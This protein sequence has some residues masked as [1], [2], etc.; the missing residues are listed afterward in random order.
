MSL[1]YS[2]CCGRF[3]GNCV[4]LALCGCGLPFT[5]AENAL[6][7]YN[8]PRMSPTN[9]AL[10]PERK[11]LAPQNLILR[12]AVSFIAS[13]SHSHTHTRVAARNYGES[14]NRTFLAA[15]ERTSDGKTVTRR[16]SLRASHAPERARR[17]A[18]QLIQ[19]IKI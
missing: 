16:R 2:R 9:K 11:A 17:R 8:E 3:N 1:F 10:T 7:Y 18:S 13:P 19:S 15:G 12:D 5:A 4:W 6:N 14:S